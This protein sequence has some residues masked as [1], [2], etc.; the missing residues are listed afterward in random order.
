MGFY[1]RV[2]AVTGLQGRDNRHVRNRKIGCL[3]FLVVI[4]PCSPRKKNQDILSLFLGNQV[5]SFVVC[6]VNG[7]GNS[8][9]LEKWG[10]NSSKVS[11][12]LCSRKE[13]PRV[14]GRQMEGTPH[15]CTRVA[16]SQAGEFSFKHQCP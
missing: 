2:E 10:A 15:P 11:S 16:P 3:L 8:S 14:L 6:P 13:G 5:T 9:A 1:A 7:L 12:F 4:D